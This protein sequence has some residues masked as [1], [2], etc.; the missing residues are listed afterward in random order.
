MLTNLSAQLFPL[1]STPAF[2]TAPTVQAPNP[3]PTQLHA[4]SLATFAT[5]LLE[6]FDELGLGIDGD[7]RGD[8]LKPI[9]EGLVS[10]IGRVVNPLVTDIRSAIMPLLEAL[11]HPASISPSTNAKPHVGPKVTIYQHPSLVALQTTMPIY[12]RALSRYTASLTS[13]STLATFILCVIWRGL[14]ALSHRSVASPSPPASPVLPPMLVK[15]QRGS[16]PANPQVTPPSPRFTIKLPPSRPPSPPTIHIPSSAAADARALYDLLCLLPRPAADKGITRLA[17][18]AVD[19][20]FDGLKALSTLLETVQA[21][22]KGKQSDD[23]LQDTLRV[24]TEDLPTLISLPVL[25][26]AYG[27]GSSG[28]SVDETLSVA[29]MLGLSSDEYR[30]GCLAGFGRAEECATAVAQRVLDELQ[31]DAGATLPPSEIGV[32]AKWLE[33]EVAADH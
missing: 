23:K 22:A 4:L 7:A 30:T 1:L 25:L 32:V 19:E 28:D 2:H 27:S 16:V 6:T 13:Q 33:G 3:N 10:T 24:L 12:S 5:E 15:G 11:E 9:R 26:H 17:R 20:A 31:A 18:E 29:A 8:G 14:V 21:N